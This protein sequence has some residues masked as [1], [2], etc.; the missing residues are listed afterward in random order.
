MIGI[1]AVQKDSRQQWHASGDE[2]PS[3]INKTPNR[4]MQIC[5]ALVTRNRRSTPTKPGVICARWSRFRSGDNRTPWHITWSILQSTIV[6]FARKK[7]F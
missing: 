5:P 6:L 4:L 2:R 3:S 1:S 7:K